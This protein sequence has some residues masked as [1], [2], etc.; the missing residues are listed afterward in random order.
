MNHTPQSD[1]LHIGLFGKCNSGKSSLINAITGQYTAIVS[2]IAGTTTDLVTKSMEIAGLGPCLFM[3]TAGFDDASNLAPERLSKT[4]LAIEKTDVALI[5]CT[6]TNVSEEIVWINKFIQRGTPVLVVVNQHNE[7]L[8]PQEV[9]DAIKQTTHADAVVVNAKTGE[10]KEELI[11]AIIKIQRNLESV[12]T[13][14]GNLVLPGDVVMLVMPQDAQ[15]PRGRLIL[16]QVQTIRELLDK[17]C[18]IVNTTVTQMSRAIDSLK[19]PPALVITDSQAFEEVSRLT[20]ANSKL[21]SFSVLFAH[22]KGDIKEFI[23]GAHT[24]NTLTEQSRIL[25]AEACTHA[26]LSEDIGRVKIPAMLRKRLGSGLGIDIVGGTDF[27]QDLSPYHLII[28]C[29][30]CMFNQRYVKSRIERAKEQKVPITNYGIT[31]AY[32]KGILDKVVYPD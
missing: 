2:E 26:P 14:T 31:I 17:D 20:P 28:H 7:K 19:N 22:Y 3:D 21:T 12:N 25:I 30:G 11:Q 10:G 5:V 23:R 8:N 9:I 15:A 13:I 32:L 27:P 16:P 4:Q 29:G 24:I 6:D 18:V 1:R